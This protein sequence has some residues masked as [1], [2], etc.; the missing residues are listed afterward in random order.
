MRK[1]LKR[2]IIITL[3]LFIS[4][5]TYSQTKIY[6]DSEWNTSTKDKAEFYRILT[7]KNDSLFHIKDFYI[8]GTLQM[9]GHISDLEKETLE[10][11]IVWYNSD[12]KKLSSAHY[13]KGVLHG[14]STTYLKNGK[15]DY[16]TEYRNGKVYDG[17]YAYSSYKQYYKKG[18]LIKQVELE[19]PN[20]FRNLE[21]RVFG[22]EKDTVYWMSNKGDKLIGIGIYHS[23]SS[24]IIDGL[25]IQNN[26]L[27]AI[28]TNYK[29]G[30]R[31]G[32]Q[33]VFYE[34]DLL[35]EQTFV[36]NTVVLERS[37]NPINGKTVEINFKDGEP[38]TGHLFQFNQIN[39][40]YN[41]FIYKEGEVLIK[42]HY[43]LVKGELKLNIEKSYKKK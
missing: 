23:S 27:I 38:N 11:K 13:K 30:K 34:G 18:K 41:E 25:D 3:F 9:E 37:I 35:S 4:T 40:Y 43:E 39:E 42:N 36:N 28:H 29:N 10:N 32:I 22:A 1:K 2:L 12:G 26:F 14:L 33:K 15:I 6:F 31:E 20:Y 16:T 24:Q 17:V 5:N 21:T 19:A 7:K 8:S